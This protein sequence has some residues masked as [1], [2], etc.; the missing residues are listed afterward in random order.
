MPRALLVK[1][2]DVL[3]AP[4]TM[5]DASFGAVKIYL[6]RLLGGAVSDD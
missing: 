3:V 5:R 1:T 2:A 6:P 4:W